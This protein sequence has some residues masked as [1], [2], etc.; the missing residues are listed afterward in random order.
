MDL[1]ILKY[2]G[3]ELSNT[4]YYS[5]RGQHALDMLAVALIKRMSV[6]QADR[7]WW[8]RM[9]FRYYFNGYVRTSKSKNYPN[10]FTTKVQSYIWSYAVYI[11]EAWGYDREELEKD[12][13]FCI[14]NMKQFK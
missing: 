1:A 12:W 14:H 13:M 2:W 9:A 8:K 7:M 5:D 3:W 4:K 11:A 6:K 10:M